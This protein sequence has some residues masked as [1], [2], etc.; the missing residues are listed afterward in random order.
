MDPQRFSAFEYL[1]R[2]ADNFKAGGALLLKGALTDAQ[3]IEM[4]F[5]FEGGE[6]FIAEQ[7]GVL[8]LYQELCAYS[9]GLTESD[10]PWHE[11]SASRP[12]EANNL[13]MGTP[14]RRAGAL[15]DA[16]MQVGLWNG[17]LSLCWDVEGLVA[18]AIALQA[19]PGWR[20]LVPLQ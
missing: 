13:A 2:D 3:V 6:L 7:I 8:P 10:H 16:V 19:P 5:R 9:G 12:A 4:R 11:F 17:K 15:F 14:W 18:K 20:P 1:Y